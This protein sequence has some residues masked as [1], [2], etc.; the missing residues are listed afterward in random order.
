MLPEM[1]H[2]T[3]AHYVLMPR[4]IAHIPEIALVHGELEL[5]SMKYAPSKPHPIT[6]WQTLHHSLGSAASAVR[7]SLS[8][9]TA[10]NLFKERACYE[11]S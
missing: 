8:V 1:P 3:S 7:L 10:R 6:N 9:W 2:K 4:T 5:M 11:N